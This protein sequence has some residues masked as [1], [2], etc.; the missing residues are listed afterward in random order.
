MSWNGEMT[1]NV[2]NQTGGTIT[3][4]LVTHTWDDIPSGTSVSVLDDGASV[5][6]GF[7]TGSGATDYWTVRFTDAA[8]ACWYRTAK[9]CGVEQE[10]FDSAKSVVINLLPGSQGFSIEMP[11]SDS[12]LDNYYDQC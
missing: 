4:L 11:I 6:F 12:C 1:C 9:Q 8:G 10:D 5:A 3:G 7:E 2:Y